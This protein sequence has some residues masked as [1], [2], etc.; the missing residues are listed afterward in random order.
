MLNQGEL[1][2]LKLSGE[3]DYF[4]GGYTGMGHSISIRVPLL[5]QKCPVSSDCRLPSLGGREGGFELD[6]P[7]HLGPPA[8][9]Q[10]LADLVFAADIR[11]GALASEPF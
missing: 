1:V 9:L 3:S 11:N 7:T 4:P 10:T 5:F 8:I 2:I 6:L